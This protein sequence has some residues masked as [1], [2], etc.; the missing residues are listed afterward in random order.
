M[1]TRR[2][3]RENAGTPKSRFRFSVYGITFFLV[4]P[5]ELKKTNNNFPGSVSIDDD[6]D[7]VET[8]LNFI[9]AFINL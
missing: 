1:V 2:N 7:D 9:E 5:A 6:D 4:H 8:A 3:W